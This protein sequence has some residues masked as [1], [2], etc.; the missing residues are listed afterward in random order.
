[1]LH[2]GSSPR[3]SAQRVAPQ[4]RSPMKAAK[5]RALVSVASKYAGREGDILGVLM[6]EFLLKILPPFAPSFKFPAIAFPSA[7][8]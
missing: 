6:G 5:W 3:L 8:K 2:G 1:M 4:L 7:L